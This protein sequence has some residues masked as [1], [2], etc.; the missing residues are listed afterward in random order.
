MHVISHVTHR[1]VIT[2]TGGYGI[3]FYLGDARRSIFCGFWKLE[4]TTNRS[5]L[6][7]GYSNCLVHIPRPYQQLAQ[8]NSLVITF[9]AAPDQVSINS[10]LLLASMCYVLSSKATQLISQLEEFAAANSL[11]ANGL[12]NIT[13]SLLII[14]FN[15]QFIM[16]C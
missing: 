10:R 14:S 9:L 11:P 15:I 7:T 3:T 8:L 16:F 4:Q 2:C 6:Y 12:K 13:K 5:K 1:D